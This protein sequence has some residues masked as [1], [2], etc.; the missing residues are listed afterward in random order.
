MWRRILLRWRTGPFALCNVYFPFSPS[1]LCWGAALLTHQKTWYYKYDAFILTR[2]NVRQRDDKEESVWLRPHCGWCHINGRLCVFVD[3][4]DWKWMYL[5][6]MIKQ[7]HSWLLTNSTFNHFC[8]NRLILFAAGG[9]GGR[10]LA[11]KL[12]S[13]LY[14]WNGTSFVHLLRHHHLVSGVCQCGTDRGQYV[15]LCTSWREECLI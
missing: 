7:L 14:L 9:W 10:V 4:G 13:L 3:V 1:L 11:V 8:W 5:S 12:P 2:V 15:Y 6:L